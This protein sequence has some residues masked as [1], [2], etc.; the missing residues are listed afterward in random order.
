MNFHI[1]GS[2]FRETP[3]EIREQ[4]AIDQSNYLSIHNSILKIPEVKDIIIIST[5]NRVEICYTTLPSDNGEKVF[6]VFADFFPTVDPSKIK[7]YFYSGQS[8]YEHLFRVVSALD[9]LVI[10]E[11][12]ITGQIKTS[13]QAACSMSEVSGYVKRVF[14]NAF[15]VAKKIR[16]ETDISKMAVSISYV[17]VEL[18]KRIFDDLED[19]T[20]LIIG[21]GEMAELAIKNLITVGCHK[22]YI[23]N[24]T[25]DNAVKLAKK[26]QASVISMEKI[27]DFLPQSDVVIAS[28]GSKEHIITYDM[29]ENSISKRKYSPMFFID[30]A[31]P[32]D[33]DPT[34]DSLDS[35]FVYNVDDLKQIVK[36]NMNFREKEA[37]KAM[38]IVLEEAEE[39]SKKMKIKDKIPFI[40]ALRDKYELIAQ[41]T[42]LEHLENKAGL[43][44][45]QSQKVELLVD[46]MIGRLLHAPTQTLR[47]KALEDDAEALLL[48]AEFFDLPMP[49]PPKKSE[50]KLIPFSKA[51]RENENR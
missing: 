28:T 23:A 5:C 39:F 11:P 26:F 41:E 27:A 8:A 1:L 48:T 37:E 25:F 46:K 32:R 24:R 49:T 18:A 30:I 15:R 22:I 34:I 13:F 16:L 38:E 20:V 4:L 42:V 51:M 12:Q 31:V 35:A 2:S 21:S 44:K 17:V 43:T 36:G 19:K 40:K 9:S 3:I 33:I 14:Q 50:R 45:E 29:A 6:Q 10:G 7:H 47:N